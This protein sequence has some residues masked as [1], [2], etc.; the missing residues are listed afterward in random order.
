VLNDEEKKPFIEEAERLRTVHKKEHPDYKYQPRRRK[1]LKGSSSVSS[2]AG[3][4]SSSSGKMH[5]DH[6]DLCETSSGTDSPNARLGSS[7]DGSHVHS[8]PTPP[9]TPEQGMLKTRINSIPV[10]SSHDRMDPFSLDCGYPLMDVSCNDPIGHAPKTPFLTTKNV[11]MYPTY[12]PDA[13]HQ[14]GSSGAWK[15]PVAATSAVEPAFGSGRSLSS[16]RSFAY[17]YQS[18]GRSS[19]A[20]RDPTHASSVYYSAD[21]KSLVQQGAPQTSYMTSS[22]QHLQFSNPQEPQFCSYGSGQST[23]NYFVPPR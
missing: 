17:G 16:P 20:D 15:P 12:A 7:S 14:W 11:Y 21:P 3:S 18:G 8:P 22:G 5:L 10:S 4:A 13:H 23:L 1:P 2:C 19:G 9:H 6:Q